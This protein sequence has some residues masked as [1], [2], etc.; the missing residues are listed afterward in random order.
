[1]TASTPGPDAR[2]RAVR[3]HAPV[4]V[5][6]VGGW[7]DTWFGSP[8]QV[9]SVAVSP[10]VEVLA[11]LVGPTDLTTGGVHLVAPDLD[12]DYRFGPRVDVHATRDSDTSGVG[13]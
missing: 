11:E 9:C 6:D 8:G 5:C 13:P 4:R 3:A 2:P 7:T 12:E 10:G 1:M